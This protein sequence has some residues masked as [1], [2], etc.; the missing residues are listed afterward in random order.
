MN[1]YLEKPF[2]EAALFNV[3]EGFLKYFSGLKRKDFCSF[4]GAR[5]NRELF[6]PAG[7]DMFPGKIVD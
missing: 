7:A 5:S 4:C 2:D 3:F 6:P 1:D